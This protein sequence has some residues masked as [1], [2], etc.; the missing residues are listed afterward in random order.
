[1]R[2]N[3]LFAYHGIPDRGELRDQ[4]GFGRV[5]TPV[6]RVWTVA[7]CGLGPGFGPSAIGGI[8]C[9]HRSCVTWESEQRRS[10]QVEGQLAWLLVNRC[11]RAMADSVQVPGWGCLRRAY[12]G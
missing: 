8:E 4:D 12:R 9:G 3:R 11:E 1:M 2:H 5:D 6:Y 7:L 10:L